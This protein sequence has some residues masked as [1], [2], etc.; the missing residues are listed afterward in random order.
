MADGKEFQFP[1]FYHLPPFFTLQPHAAVRAKQLELWKQLISEYCSFHR[2]FI[3]DLTEEPLFR[4]GQLSRQLPFEARLALAEVLVTQ[5]AAL[6]ADEVEAKE[7]PKKEGW[8]QA[9]T[10]GGAPLGTLALHFSMGRFDTAM[11]Q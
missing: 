2:L 9:T 1:A 7:V 8:K 4:N 11:G 6:W 3:I 5:Q 10:A